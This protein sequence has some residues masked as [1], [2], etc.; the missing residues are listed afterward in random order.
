MHWIEQRELYRPNVLFTL[1]TNFRF[2]FSKTICCPLL[3][4]SYLACGE[5][6]NSRN[7]WIDS[8]FPIGR[9]TD[10][11]TWF[12]RNLFTIIIIYQRVCIR[13]VGFVGWRVSRDALQM[14][15]FFRSTKVLTILAF[16]GCRSPQ[17]IH[18]WI[19]LCVLD[20]LADTHILPSCWR[21]FSLS[22][23]PSTLSL[24]HSHTHT[25]STTKYPICFNF[26]GFVCT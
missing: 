24:S 12:R 6:Y 16:A 25:H 23:V 19:L 11:Q 1:W 5:N 20:L 15:I 21:V 9:H 18:I 26:Y 7:S 3:T 8:R 2:F 17:H 22:I 10:R 13:L 4:A 14:L